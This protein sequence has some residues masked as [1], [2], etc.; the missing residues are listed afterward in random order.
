MSEYDTEL[1][2]DQELSEIPPEYQETFRQALES[3]LAE[4]EQN[5]TDHDVLLY[6][7][8]R[9]DDFQRGGFIRPDGRPGMVALSPEALYER[10]LPELARSS[11]EQTDDTAERRRTLLKMG[12]FG[13]LALLF[14]VFILRSRSE[15]ES[16]QESE[17]KSTAI[18]QSDS[19][20]PA[21]SPPLPEITVVDD[22]LQ[23][24]G[25]LGGALT[26]GR[27]SAIEL[28]YDRTEE[29]IALPI[30][31]SRPTPRGELRFNEVTMQS[32]NPVAVWLFG[33]VLNYAIGVPDSMVRNLS[34]GDRIILSAD[35]G[36]S[37][38]FV[39]AE[40]WQGTNYEASRL[41]SQNRIGLTLFALPANDAGDVSFAFA[42]YDITSEEDRTQT[43]HGVGERFSVESVGT[44]EVETIQFSHTSRGAF[45]IVIDGSV[46][47]LP[48]AQTIMLSMSSTNEQTTA[49]ELEPD[50]EGA[51]MTVFTMPDNIAGLPLFAE[52]RSLPGG[53]LAIVGLGE[54]PRLTEALQIEITRARWDAKRGEIVVAVSIHN[55]GEG[56]VFFGPK[57]VHPPSEGGDAYEGNGQVTPRLPVLVGPGETMGII[58]S[59]PPKS[60]S[61][62]L[63]IGHDLWAI[64]G[65]PQG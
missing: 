55:P 57:H 56:A 58:V 29:T 33:T 38:R 40:R 30:D 17:I 32:N 42:H 41:L 9:R 16:A 28:H 14:L 36:A 27:P 34:P 63:Q 23:T 1:D 62:Q 10:A 64:S 53:N 21:P 54:A 22:S 6:L 43:T 12:F 45:R 61:V 49:I 37:L 20:T 47:D 25:S 26:I 65:F 5:R 35:T 59:F 15:R 46:S 11:L 18:A 7:R 19:G 48:E 8:Q 51:W 52:F 60:A 24:I 2:L 3:E 39:L 4:L 50:E 44:L 31:P 13:G